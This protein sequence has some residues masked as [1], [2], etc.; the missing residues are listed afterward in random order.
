MKSPFPFPGKA[1]RNLLQRSGIFRK[2]NLT[3][4]GR[5]INCTEMSQLSAPSLFFLL[6]AVAICT[7]WKGE[8]NSTMLVMLSQS[9]YSLQSGPW[10]FIYS[11][12]DTIRMTTSRRV[13]CTGQIAQLGEMR[14]ANG[15]D[16]LVDISVDG[17]ISKLNNISIQQSPSW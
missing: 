3:S 15:R 10:L 7:L 6:C 1:E 17:R 4:K 8:I 9:Q 2:L 16:H 11:S 13:R 14:N 12:A 5:R